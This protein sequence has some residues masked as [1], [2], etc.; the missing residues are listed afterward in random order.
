MEDVSIIGIDLAKNSFQLH[1]AQ[2][3]GSV[4]FRK[5][6]SR[7]KLLDFL[8]AQP[9][10]VVA[11]AG[12]GRC[13]LFQSGSGDAVT[14]RAHSLAVAITACWLQRAGLRLTVSLGEPHSRHYGL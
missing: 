8:A 14:A 4:V 2:E 9:P 12:G 1:G 6:M 3:D 7:A 5:K 10:C 13:C 11:M